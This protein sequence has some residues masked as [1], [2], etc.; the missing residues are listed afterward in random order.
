MLLFLNIALLVFGAIS[1]ATGLSGRTRT[2]KGL[3]ISG[4]IALSCALGALGTGVAR[5][6]ITEKQADADKKQ[7]KVEHQETEQQLETLITLVKAKPGTAS[8]AAPAHIGRPTVPLPQPELIG[9]DQIVGTVTDSNNHP[10]SGAKVTLVTD[11]GTVLEVGTTSDNGEFEI[12]NIGPSLGIVGAILIAK[13]GLPTTRVRVSLTG[14]QKLRI[15][16]PGQ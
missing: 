1:S 16:M 12:R 6:L 3:A 10:V 13:D 2:R 11:K 14:G 15:K 5:E 4:W 8:V 7:A 9:F